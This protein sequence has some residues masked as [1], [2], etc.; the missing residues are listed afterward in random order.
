MRRNL[1]S[2]GVGA[3]PTPT[4]G[5]PRRS[6]PGG[7]HKPT[8]T[9]AIREKKY[10][11]GSKIEFGDV[12]YGTTDTVYKSF[13]RAQP[14]TTIQGSGGEYR[15]GWDLGDSAGR[16][17]NIAL[18]ATVRLRSDTKLQKYSEIPSGLF[19]RYPTGTMKRTF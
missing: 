11:V 4:V 16:T 19:T 18:N 7:C 6:R 17:E 2:V 5:K 1:A 10:R 15:A 14:I 3:A 13:G 9:V 12:G 8:S